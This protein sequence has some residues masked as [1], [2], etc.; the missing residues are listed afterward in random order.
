MVR[1]SLIIYR[2][3]R[4]SIENPGINKKTRFM[5]VMLLQGPLECKTARSSQR[6]KKERSHKL[7]MFLS[8]K[9]IEKKS[10]NI[11]HVHLLSPLQMS[12]T[13]STINIEASNPNTREAVVVEMV[14]LIR[15]SS[16]GWENC[17]ALPDQIPPS[18]G[19]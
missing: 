11:A 4:K 14:V 13:L 6:I 5:R 1:D 10:V 9:L 15:K 12:T 7:K 2:A 16:C 19:T 3:V 8:E 18:S 17:E